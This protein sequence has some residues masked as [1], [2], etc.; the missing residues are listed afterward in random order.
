MVANQFKEILKK[1][2]VIEIEALGY[3]FD[4]VYM[5]AMMIDNDLTKPDDMVT[6][7][8]RKGYKYKDRVLKHAQVKVNKNEV[9]E[10]ILEERK[11]EQEKEGNE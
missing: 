1:Y 5:D 6:A 9:Q 7:V 4:P 8:L 3:P 10:Q 11:Q 2:D